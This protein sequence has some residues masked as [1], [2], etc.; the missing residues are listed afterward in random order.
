MTNS[1]LLQA[2]IADRRALH[3]IPEASL[4]ESK[5]AAY[6]EQQLSAMGYAPKR[7]LETG[8]YVYM[9]GTSGSKTY[10]FRADMDALP[11][12]EESDVSY[13][14][15]HKG[16][17]HACGHD[18]HMA[19]LLGFA[20]ALKNKSLKENILLIFQ[21][22]EE[23]IGGAKLICDA[24]LLRKYKVDA[25]FGLHLFPTVPEGVIAYKAGAMMATNAEV[26]VDVLG[27]SGHGAM[28]HT[29]KDSLV[30]AAEL[31]LAYQTIVSRSIN[32]M[33]TAV[34]SFGKMSG[35]TIRNIVA[36]SARLEGTLRAFSKENLD[37]LMERIQSINSGFSQAY[38]TKIQTE[39]NFCYPPVIND[40]ALT[41]NIHKAFADFKTQPAQ[42]SAGAEDFSFYQQEVPGFFFFLG[43]R[44]EKEG[45]V[46]PLHNSKFNFN[47]EVLGLGVK[48]FLSIARQLKTIE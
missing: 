7:I 35:G 42:P 47:E 13:A 4:E 36:G 21:P 48:S 26:N 30:V 32:P 45:L 24:G 14:S 11:L 39:F 6:L 2:I 46:A 12:L 33:D 25:I 40:E 44:N 22:A 27:K 9:P 10:A 5:T 16:M 19:I 20:R 34:V 29:A 31:L 15:K 8:V 43:T 41:E 28:P 38:Q 3:Q 1:N 37:L 17:M 18:G 23:N